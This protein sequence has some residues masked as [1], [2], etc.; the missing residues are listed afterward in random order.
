MREFGFSIG[1]VA[2]CVV[3]NLNAFSKS[4]EHPSAP[5][6]SLYIFLNKK[7]IILKCRLYRITL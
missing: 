7:M 1:V 6:Q 3:V 4:E 2:V 5:K